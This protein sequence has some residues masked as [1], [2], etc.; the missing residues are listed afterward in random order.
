LVAPVRL[1]VSGGDDDRYMPFAPGDRQSSHPARRHACVRPNRPRNPEPGCGGGLSVGQRG[2]LPP[3]TVATHHDWQ[4]GSGARFRHHAGISQCWRFPLRVVPKPARS[5]DAGHELPGPRHGQGP[6]SGHT[7]AV[8]VV[9]PVRLW[10]IERFHVGADR[11]LRPHV[12][13]VFLR[14]VLGNATRQLQAAVL[15]RP[16]LRRSARSAPGRPAR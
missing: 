8:R 13:R 7:H 14:A 11:E 6:H 15:A 10:P 16:A 12:L 4:S 3:S 9:V 1:D 2:I 5:R